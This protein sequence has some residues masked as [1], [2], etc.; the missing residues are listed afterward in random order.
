MKASFVRTWQDY[1]QEVRDNMHKNKNHYWIKEAETRLIESLYYFIEQNTPNASGAYLD[2][3]VEMLCYIDQ[4]WE[5]HSS[6]YD[7]LT[8]WFRFKRDLL[9]NI[10]ECPNKNYEYRKG[11]FDT[12][13]LARKYFSHPITQDVIYH[14]Q[15]ET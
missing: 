12:L 10:F 15:F 1:L 4:L 14:Y 8:A 2:G 11:F 5:M 3:S 13:S 6:K 7:F 9:F